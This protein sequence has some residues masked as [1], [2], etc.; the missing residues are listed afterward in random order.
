[1][2]INNHSLRSFNLYKALQNNKFSINIPKNYLPSYE[3][4]SNKAIFIKPFREYNEGGMERHIAV[5]IVFDSDGN[6]I[7]GYDY[8]FIE[9]SPTNIIARLYKNASLGAGYT[10][11][12]I[13]KLDDVSLTWINTNNGEIIYAFNTMDTSKLR[14]K[15]IIND[16]YKIAD[17]IE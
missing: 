6:V 16:C 11:D 17:T 13:V 1:M 14:N 4:M 10:L 2:K 9:L 15:N 5:Y 8:P 7:H 12:Y 3:V